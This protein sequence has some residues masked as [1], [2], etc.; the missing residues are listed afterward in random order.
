MDYKK[1][2]LKKVQYLTVFLFLVLI[3]NSLNYLQTVQQ[4]RHHSEEARKD[5]QTINNFEKAPRNVTEA[6]LYPLRV[7]IWLSEVLLSIRK[8]VLTTNQQMETSLFKVEKVQMQM[9][10][11]NFY[12][13]A[14]S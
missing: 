1:S 13:E 8:A 10:D 14:L 12:C 3:F 9:T 7:E 4:N 6:E 11:K 5:K 2:Q